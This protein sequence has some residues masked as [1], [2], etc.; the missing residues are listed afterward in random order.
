MKSLIDQALSHD[1]QVLR[2]TFGTVT[3]WWPG[4]DTS[5]PQEADFSVEIRGVMQGETRRRSADAV[6][7]LDRAHP[8]TTFHLPAAVIPA[9]V[10]A[11][12]E[13]LFLA[14][15]AKSTA[16]LYRVIES[17]ADLGYL[18]IVSEEAS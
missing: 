18:E 11:R 16:T 15:A 9:G 10:P 12:K 8:Q 3:I 5:R 14:G 17:R 13:R 6:G 4:S 1:V 7:L 2:D